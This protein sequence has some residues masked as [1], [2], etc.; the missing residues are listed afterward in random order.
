[1]YIWNAR[2]TIYEHLQLFIF[3]IARVLKNHKNHFQ[4][5]VEVS[6]L[7]LPWREH[8]RHV[9]SNN[10]IS[11][12]LG[13]VKKRR[14]NHILLIMLEWELERRQW[15]CQSYIQMLVHS[16]YSAIVHCTVQCILCAT[17]QPLYSVHSA[18]YN[19]TYI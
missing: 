8:N 14:H 2:V 12:T 16:L 11:K 6:C 15:E 7:H 10:Y 19:M 1:M 17:V 13:V 3:Y 5:Y 18:T 9:V 4:K